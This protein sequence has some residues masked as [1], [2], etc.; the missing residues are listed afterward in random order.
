MF[1]KVA[2]II[3]VILQFGAFFIVLGLIPKT[4]FNISWITIS[5]AFFLMAL[6]RT[7]ELTEIYGSNIID[8][9]TYS[10]N[11]LAV[12]ISILMFIASF[13]IRQ[14][15]ILREKVDKIRTENEAKI[16][17]AIIRTEEKERRKFSKELHDGLGPILSSVKMAVTAIDKT[18]I[19]EKN[20]KIISKTENNIDNAI[21]SVKE[22]SNLLNP[23][24]L[25]RFGL[26]KAI[27][28][29]S[30]GIITKLPFDFNI[31]TNFDDKRYSYKIEVTIYRIVCELI[32]NTLKHSSAS[33]AEL[34]LY[35]YNSKL[36]LF[37][38]DN[39][40]GFDIKTNDSDGM[41][42]M[43]IN[44]RVKSLGGE[45]EVTSKPGH[46]FYTKITFVV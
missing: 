34:S 11:W 40:V 37:Y 42:L 24:I 39:G 20:S 30:D 23:Q 5:I 9:K 27:K 19:N 45:I 35:D 1:I 26:V 21:N 4:K 16:L 18:N 25:E 22:I 28:E 43:N 44:T 33:K 15:F 46:G 29:F 41:G 38:F 2:L 14:I 3:S 8:T 17:N 32:N 10:S 13:Y 31:Q 12:L 6:R 7:I 36:E